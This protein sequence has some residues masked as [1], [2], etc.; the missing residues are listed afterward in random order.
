MLDVFQ[1]GL[2][3]DENRKGRARQLLVVLPAEEYGQLRARAQQET[4]TPDQ[5]ATH[6]VRV[7]LRRRGGPEPEML[8]QEPGQ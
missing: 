3:M 1:K 2:A 4:R 7:A 8:A 5:Q 6:L